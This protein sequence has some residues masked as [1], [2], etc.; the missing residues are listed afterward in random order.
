MSDTDIY[1]KYYFHSP[2]YEGRIVW[3]VKIETSFF[4]NWKR[5]EL[6]GGGSIASKSYY[7]KYF[8]RY[9]VCAHR[10]W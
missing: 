1:R 9:A 7:M 6:N 5:I 4:K 3:A 8:P 10:R 2:E